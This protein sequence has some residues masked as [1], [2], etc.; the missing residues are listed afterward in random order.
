MPA[1]RGATSQTHRKRS[2]SPS[3]AAASSGSP[4]P[5]ARAQRGLRVVVL[6]ARRRSAR[7]ASRVA[8]GMLAPVTEADAGERAL[9]RARPGE[10]AR[11]GRRSPP[12]CGRRDRRRL[13]RAAARSSSRATATRPRR[14]SA[15]T[16]CASGSA[17]GS[18]GC[19]RRSARARSSPRSRPTCALALDV[20]DDHAV[21]PRA[22][23]RRAGGGRARRRACRARRR[24]RHARAPRPGV[25]LAAASASR[26]STSSSPPALGGALAG[27]PRASRCGRSRAR[28]CACATR[29][30][31]ACVDRVLRYEGGYLVPRGD[32]RYVLGA[33][34]E[35]RGFD[36]DRHR[37]RRLRAAARRAP[38]CVPGVLE[39]DVEEA[40]AGLRPGTPDNAPLLGARA[41]LDGLVWA[42]GHHR[43]GILLA[44]RDRRRSSPRELGGEPRRAARRSPPQR[45][46]EVRGVICVNGEPT[47]RRDGATVARRCSPTLG[48]DPDARRRRRG[49]RRGR[50]AR[51]VGRR[52]RARRRARRG[53]DAMQGG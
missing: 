28:S 17:C 27:L 48:V 21:D 33:T 32:G 38:S 20:P 16:R 37:G 30:A 51:R 1:K 40:A 24:A 29:T 25:E 6:D 43:N 10:R 53:R 23:R 45:F 49:R 2:T 44:P 11:A 8:A 47:E 4:S 15:S 34:M 7:G 13:P 42:T 18:S 3:S 52:A 39:L 41:A 36:T 12:S 22:R 31:P 9:L 5:G 35:E 14:S 19:C 46:A 50:P 26:P